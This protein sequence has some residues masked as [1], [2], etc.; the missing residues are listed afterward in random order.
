M[1]CSSILPKLQAAFNFSEADQRVIAMYE[2]PD[3]EQLNKLGVAFQNVQENIMQ[4]TKVSI[5]R[6]QGNNCN[7]AN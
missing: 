1:P 3:F 4:F 5:K 7:D 6:C 2:C